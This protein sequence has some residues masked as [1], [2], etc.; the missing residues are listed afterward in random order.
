MIADF[1]IVG[2]LPTDMNDGY[3]MLTGSG[4]A[5]TIFV[6]RYDEYPSGH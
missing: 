6:N 4:I 3:I 2:I 1:H 5:G